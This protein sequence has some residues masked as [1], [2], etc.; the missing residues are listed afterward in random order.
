MK[1][2]VTHLLISLT[3]MLLTLT[4]AKDACHLTKAFKSIGWKKENRADNGQPIRVL[5]GLQA[6]EPHVLEKYFWNVSD[7]G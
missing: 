5:I 6:A 1:K 3:T 4:L 2:R 7:P